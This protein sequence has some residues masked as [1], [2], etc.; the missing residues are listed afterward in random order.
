MA[1]ARDRLRREKQLPLDDAIRIACEVAD[2]L[3]YAHARGIIHR[4]IKPD[5]ILLSAEHARVADF[6]I[7]R[8]QALRID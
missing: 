1:R 8:D 4:D 3:S 6:G 7:A 5:N 2:A